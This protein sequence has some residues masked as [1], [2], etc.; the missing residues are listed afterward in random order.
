VAAVELNRIWHFA[1]ETSAKAAHPFAG[2][3][4]WL[5]AYDLDKLT[6]GAER[7]LLRSWSILGSG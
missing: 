5:S 6:A 4:K 2:A 7:T 3:A 1:D